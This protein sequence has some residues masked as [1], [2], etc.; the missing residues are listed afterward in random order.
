MV[1]VRAR[2]GM[3]L[4]GCVALAGCGATVGFPLH[5]QQ[6]PARLATFLQQRIGLDSARIASIEH[7]DAIVKVLD[8]ENKRDVAVFG[9]INVDVPRSEERRVGK[10]CRSRWSP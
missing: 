9:I 5:A 4:L 2:G 10:E 6:P 7:G 8:T 3:R 1:Q